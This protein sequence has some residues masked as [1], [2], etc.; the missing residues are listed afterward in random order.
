MNRLILTFLCFLTAT[1]LAVASESINLEEHGK[2]LLKAPFAARYNFERKFHTSWA[3]ST[4]TQ[5]R[6]FLTNW[7]QDLLNEQKKDQVEKKEEQKARLAR[8]KERE[9]LLKKEQERLKELKAESKE[10]EKNFQDRNKNL[11]A[12]VKNQESQIRQM[13]SSSH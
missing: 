13:R 5:R 10:Q 12:T 6:I 8:Q 7:H 1:T 2:D 11:H 3:N 4:Y 9:A